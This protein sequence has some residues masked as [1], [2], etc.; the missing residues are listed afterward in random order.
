MTGPIKKHAQISCILEIIRKS[1]Y[2]NLPEYNSIRRTIDF[3]LKF[4]LGE[5]IIEKGDG[6]EPAHAVDVMNKLMDYFDDET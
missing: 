2:E 3:R 6:T 5:P 4:E 1:R